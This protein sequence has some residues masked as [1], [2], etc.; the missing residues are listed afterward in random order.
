MV[1]LVVVAVGAA[2]VRVIS[3]LGEKFNE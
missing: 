2:V 1:K 3:R